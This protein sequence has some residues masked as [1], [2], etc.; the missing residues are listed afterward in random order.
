M[1][2]RASNESLMVSDRFPLAPPRR[3]RSGM[4]V[5]ECAAVLPILAI[6][7][8]GMFELSRVI[9]VA[10]IL[11][12]AARRGC[13]IAVTPGKANA[14][15][16]TVINSIMTD[17]GLPNATTTISVMNQTSGTWSVADCSTAKGGDPVSLKVGVR[18][19][20]ALLFWPSTF[21]EP[22]SLIESQSLTM[23]KQYKSSDTLP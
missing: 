1:Y 22:G 5:V 9:K 14:D 16:T 23:I 21:Y 13:R 18:V 4:A 17:N 10:E 20:D 12:D 3:R 6:L 19:S 8:V 15:V 7:L 2:M 11:D